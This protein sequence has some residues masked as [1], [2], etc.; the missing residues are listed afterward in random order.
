MIERV[1]WCD[2]RGDGVVDGG[3]ENGEMKDVGHIDTGELWVARMR[4]DARSWLVEIASE[5]GVVEWDEIGASVNVAVVAVI[6]GSD[7][8]EVVI[9]FGE[10]GGVVAFGIASAPAIDFAVAVAAFAVIV[11]VGETAEIVE[12]V[13]FVV[14]SVGVVGAIDGLVVV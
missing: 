14:E 3:H 2:G 6:V 9:A 10:A 8:F 12:F 4:K 1:P 13:R 7:D 5:F 11:F